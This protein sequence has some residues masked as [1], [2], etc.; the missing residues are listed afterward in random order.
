MC[1]DQSGSMLLNKKQTFN[2]F[3]VMMLAFCKEYILLCIFAL[4]LLDE[5]TKQ[6]KK[7]NRNGHFGQP[8]NN[9]YLFFFMDLS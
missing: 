7:K 6:I 4:K 2:V 5:I 1:Q 3:H 8:S 9:I